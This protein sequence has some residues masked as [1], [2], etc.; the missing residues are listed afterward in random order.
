MA[1]I[2][3]LLP[4]DRILKAAL[5]LAAKYHLDICYT[6]ITSYADLKKLGEEA[7]LAGAEIIKIGRAHV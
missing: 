3:L 1:K 7:G 5:E 6:A 2:A 4:S